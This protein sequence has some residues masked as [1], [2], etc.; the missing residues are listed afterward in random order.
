[1]IIKTVKE[2]FMIFLSDLDT[3]EKAEVLKVNADGELKRRLASFGLRKN[4][5]VEVRFVTLLKRTMEI[6]IGS[7]IIAIRFDEA[8]MI[9]V[10]KI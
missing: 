7:T 5:S 1:M 4:S 8:D 3:G 6:K 2:I 9:E 10:K